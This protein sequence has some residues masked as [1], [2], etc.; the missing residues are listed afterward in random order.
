MK[1]VVNNGYFPY[2]LVSRIPSI[3]SR[4]TIWATF[5]TFFLTPFSRRVNESVN[6]E[7][8]MTERDGS[9]KN[10]QGF[11][12]CSNGIPAPS[13]GCQLHPKRMVNWHPVTESFGQ[14]LEGSGIYRVGTYTLDITISSIYLAKKTSGKYS[15]LCRLISLSHFVSHTSSSWWLNHPSE[16]Y[17]KVKLDHLPR[18]RG[19][20]NLSVNL[21]AWEVSHRQVTLNASEE[22]QSKPKRPPKWARLLKTCV[23]KVVSTNP[24]M[25]HMRK[26]II[27][28]MYG[29]FTYTF[30]P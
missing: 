14:S 24:W 28:S 22:S 17:A 16:K 13:E 11:G 6:T 5:K 12:H 23:L 8:S 21:T 7:S 27:W 29:I 18:D 25:K 30:I 26:S 10:N 19:E 2:Q 1:P 20:K 15:Y 3:N 9:T 4:Q